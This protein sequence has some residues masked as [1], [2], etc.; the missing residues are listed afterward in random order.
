M[1]E[2][3]AVIGAG[4]WGTTLADLLAK[5]G[6]A[7]RVWSFEADIAEAINRERVNPTYLPDIRLSDRLRATADIG[8]ALQ[9]AGVI[10]QVTPS[11]HVRAVL[12]SAREAVPRDAVVVSASKGIET[13]TLE[14]MA[15]VL[16]EA[17]PEPVNGRLSFLSG[18]TF[19]L[20]VAR[21][22]PTAVTVASQSPKLARRMQALFQTDYLR[23]YT[24]PDVPGVELGGALK[25]VIALAAGMATGLGLGYN[26]LA[27]LITRGLAEITRLGVALGANP[28]TFAG[29]AGMGDLILTCTGGLSRNR[30]VG[31]QL[32]RGR[33][34][35][36]VLSEMKMV[37][38]GVET[39]R[40]T[41][42]LAARHGVE[43]PI[44]HEVRAVL[45]EGRPPAEAVRNL[46]TREPKP[47]VWE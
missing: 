41:C 21:E 45:F 26:T 34:L 40:A 2:Q 3:V 24:S 10:L 33:S 27:A 17:L 25:N 19:A 14:T 7:V 18:P 23:V 1:T 22:A 39:T 8:E 32:G 46:M 31:E 29:L 43:M 13:S 11:Q 9:G 36:D 42:E 16:D 38:E 35:T 5:K 28:M 12:G 20:E 6:H 15:E 44:A 47:E 30:S 4:S 37:A